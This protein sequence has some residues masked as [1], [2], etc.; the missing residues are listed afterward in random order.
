MIKK[1]KIYL[2]GAGPGSI[3]LQT[4]RCAQLV[5]EA[6]VIVYDALVNPAILDDANPEAEFIYVGKRSGK[7]CFKQQEINN[8]LIEKAQAGYSVLRLKGGDPF[9][10]GRGG[11]E[12]MAVHASGLEYEIV[13][14]VTAGVSV[15]A[16]FGIPVTHRGVATSV[17]LITGFSK[18]HGVPKLNW[19]ALAGMK[20]TLV[21]YMGTN[22]API[23]TENLIKAG[24]DP[25]TPMAIISEGTLPTQRII[26]DRLDAFTSDYADYST[27]APGLIVIG[28]VVD[29]H[30]AYE[31]V[32]PG[33]L[34][35]K[36]IIVTRSYNQSSTLADTLEGHGAEVFVLPT[37]KVAPVTE[38]EEIT[39]ALSDLFRTDWVIFSSVSGVELFFK[40]LREA[41][42]DFRSLSHLR[43]ATIGK[44]TTEALG[45]FGFLPDFTPPYHKTEH[46][47]RTFA[48][49]HPEI[50]SQRILVSGSLLTK[51]LF[52]E[53]LNALGAECRFVPLYDN[54]PIEYYSERIEMMHSSV[55]DWILFCSSSAV[56]NFASLVERHDLRAW[57]EKC[58]MASIGPQTSNAL[59]KYGYT[60]ALEP[61]KA[62]ID[63]LVEALI[64]ASKE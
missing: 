46:F 60:V 20:G 62:K 30:N 48:E 42:V 53:E 33:S 55:P 34:A 58:K 18:H 50:R 14:G 47:I 51:N 40:R 16:F 35:S 45:H 52:V 59:R 2:A 27:L 6:D 5:K 21:F 31:W 24:M 39:S 12:M 61:S 4:V 37:M 28:D 9:V 8:I 56:E 38:S 7:I 32:K 63:S 22:T 23:I 3:G 57:A 26:S 1:G 29:F 41:K 64:E 11:E 10:F 49:T 15:P 17:S 19:E 25:A 43:F 36:R 44:V 13:P 54:V